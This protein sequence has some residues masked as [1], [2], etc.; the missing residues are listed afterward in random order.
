MVKD[1]HKKVIHISNFKC[2]NN[3][4]ATLL[5]GMDHGSEEFISK[6]ILYFR[7]L[8][9]YVNNDEYSKFRLVSLLEDFYVEDKGF[10]HNLA[11]NNKHVQGLYS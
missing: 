3:T 7:S 10:T 6:A 4:F 11:F 8:Y 5:K 1:L 2:Q 9:M